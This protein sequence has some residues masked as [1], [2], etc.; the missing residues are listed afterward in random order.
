MTIDSYHFAID[1]ANRINILFFWT[2]FDVRNLPFLPNR[3]K[4]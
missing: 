2:Y 1:N 3:L 4:F